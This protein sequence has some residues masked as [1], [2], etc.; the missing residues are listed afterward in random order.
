M[1]DRVE[2][3]QQ[4]LETVDQKTTDQPRQQ[5]QGMDINMA[6]TPPRTTFIVA[7]DRDALMLEKL[8]GMEQAIESLVPLLEKIITHLEAQT[9]PPTSPWRP[10]RISTTS[11]TPVRLKGSWWQP[12]WRLPLGRCAGGNGSSG[13]RHERG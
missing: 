2:H 11:R 8:A 9:P 5:E 12:S 13:A 6:T 3:L 10:T 1:L 4:R 7:T